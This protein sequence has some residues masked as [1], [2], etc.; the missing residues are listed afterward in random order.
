MKKIIFYI[1]LF[2]NFTFTNS[3]SN[4]K[5]YEKIDLFGEVI[6]KIKKRLCR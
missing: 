5:L 2:L 6:E 3:Y 4:N 1:I